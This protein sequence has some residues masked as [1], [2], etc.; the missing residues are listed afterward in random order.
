MAPASKLV[1]SVAKLGTLIMPESTLQ[2]FYILS[3]NLGFSGG[4]FAAN[5]GLVGSKDGGEYLGTVWGLH[6]D[7]PT[8]FNCNEPALLY[9]LST[10]TEYQIPYTLWWGQN[11]PP[12]FKPY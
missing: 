8:V 5:T 3:E 12:F 2:H 1:I 7:F 4:C 10:C 6:P 11:I 9:M